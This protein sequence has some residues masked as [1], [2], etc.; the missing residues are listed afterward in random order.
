MC[1]PSGL[2]TR[3][4]RRRVCVK[5]LP[6]GAGSSWAGNG[7]PACPR[8]SRG[9]RRRAGT[10]G[11][12]PRRWMCRRPATGARGGGGWRR[13]GLSRWSATSRD[14]SWE[15]PSDRAAHSVADG[16]LMTDDTVDGCPDAVKA[17]STAEDTGVCNASV[18]R[19]AASEHL[20]TPSRRSS[21]AES[22][23]LR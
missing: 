6:A 1:Q 4:I 5:R 19:F 23:R 2:E 15:V 18:A 16:L 8:R 22:W 3:Q 7:S 21:L 9:G 13:R 11:R 12:A 17:S 10:R 14:V 20:R